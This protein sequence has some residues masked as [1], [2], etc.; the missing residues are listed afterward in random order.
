MA[1]SHWFISLIFGLTGFVNLSLPWAIPIGFAYPVLW[2]R[3]LTRGLPGHASDLNRRAAKVH[4]ALLA[5]LLALGPVL[6][7]HYIR[8]HD[9][10]YFLPRQDAAAL[11]LSRWHAQHPATPLH[12]VGGQ[13]SENG[14]LAFYGDPHL[15]SLPGTP[16]DP[17]AQIN[18]DTNWAREGG[19]LICKGG[20]LDDTVSL[21]Q[22]ESNE[23]MAFLQTP[24]AHQAQDWL[25]RHHRPVTP[26][27]VRARRDGAAFPNAPTY[28][29]VTFDYLP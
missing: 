29:Y 19:V 24:C 9:H 26:H 3:N 25:S 17:R 7:R 21:P 11:I 8:I 20:W 10:N 4:V 14:F 12:W 1:V 13:W 28:V 16:D 18:P 6:A 15:F 2:V 27:W 23:L 22:P 5:G